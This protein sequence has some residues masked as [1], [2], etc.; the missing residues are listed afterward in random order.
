MG[1]PLSPVV[2]DLILQRFESSI[3]NDLTYKPT[4]YHRYVDDIALSV[5]FDQLNG[6]LAKFNSFHRRLKFTMEMECGGAQTE[7]F[8]SYHYQT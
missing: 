3:L 8:G 4:F 2:A 7:L 5:P 6:L 1:S